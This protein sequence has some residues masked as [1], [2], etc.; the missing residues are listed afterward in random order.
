MNSLHSQGVD[1]LG[2]GLMVEARAPDGL[3]EAFSD[4]AAPGF[5]LGVQWHPEWQFEKNA[6]SRALFGALGKASRQYA[7]TSR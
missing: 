3:V 7:G 6:F 4:P 1:R 5:A 2:Q